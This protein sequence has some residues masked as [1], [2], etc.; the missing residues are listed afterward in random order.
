MEMKLGGGAATW[1]AL[2]LQAWNV[3]EQ[4]VKQGGTATKKEIAV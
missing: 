2:V 1:E 4:P 3:R